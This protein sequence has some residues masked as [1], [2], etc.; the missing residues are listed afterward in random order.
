MT[1]TITLSVLALLA[2][3]QAS[4]TAFRGEIR[5]HLDSPIDATVAG[6]GNLSEVQI[7]IADSLFALGVPSVLQASRETVL[8]GAFNSAPVVMAS[9]MLTQVAPGALRAEVRVRGRGWNDRIVARVRG[10]LRAA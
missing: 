4:E 3:H 9:V 2:S 1:F 7:C 10:C 5:E 6:G 8:I